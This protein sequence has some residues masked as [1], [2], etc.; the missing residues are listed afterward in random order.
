MT[1]YHYKLEIDSETNVQELIDYTYRQVENSVTINGIEVYNF[2]TH[3]IDYDALNKAAQTKLERDSY[4][5]PLQIDSAW[6][7]MQSILPNEIRCCEIL[8]YRE[9]VGEYFTH[10]NFV[11]DVPVE[12]RDS[13]RQDLASELID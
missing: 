12:M 7:F 11:R 9:G 10:K 8:V 1:S 3:E 6:Q 13:I 4:V 5:I 2:S